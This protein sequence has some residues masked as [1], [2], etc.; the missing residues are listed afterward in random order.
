MNTTTD[1]VQLIM[2]PH[3]VVS[4]HC[5]QIW[6]DCNFFRFMSS[7]QFS[8]NFT[9][10]LFHYDDRI[11]EWDEF[12]WSKRAIHVSV[13]KQTKWWVVLLC[14]CHAFGHQRLKT[15]FS[16]TQGGMPSDFYILTLLPVMTTYLSGMKILVLNIL[17]QRRKQQLILVG[18]FNGVPLGKLISKHFLQVHWAC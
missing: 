6:K 15:Y 17:M 3:E 5:V 9:I 16:F 11:T 7:L 13:R 18:F 1:A 4:S 2:H 14:V 12:E 10:M 8:E